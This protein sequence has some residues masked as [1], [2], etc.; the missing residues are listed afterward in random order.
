[1]GAR[2][3]G[4]LAPEERMVEL[5][6]FDPARLERAAGTATTPRGPR[7]KCRQRPPPP[8]PPAQNEVKGP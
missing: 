2:E 4:E 3:A 1:M 5:A 6:D 8:P 7:A